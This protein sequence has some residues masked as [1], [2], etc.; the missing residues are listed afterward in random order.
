MKDR[1]NNNHGGV[2]LF[3]KDRINNNHG[4][5]GLFVKDRINN[6]HGGVGLFVKDRINNNHGGVGLFV[7]DRINNNHGGVGLFVKDRINNNHGGVG[8]F[9]KDR[10]NNN[11]GGVELF[12]KDRINNNHGGVG[13]FVKDRINN[14]HGGV[15][16]FVKDRINNNHG[17]VGLFVKDRI[18]N[19]HGGVGL[20]VKDRINNNHGGVGL[21]VKDRINNNHGGVGLFVKDR[22]NNNHGGVG[23]FVKDRI[24]NNH[25]GVGLFV[26][27]RIKNYIQSVLYHNDDCIYISFTNIPNVVFYGC[28]IPPNESLYY[29]NDIFA[30]L[31]SSLC[32]E[33]RLAVIF[34]D[35]NAKIKDFND[36]LQGNSLYSYNLEN[37]QQNRNGDILKSICINND[38]VVVNGLIEKYRKFDDSMTYKRRNKWISRIDMCLLSPTLISLIDSS[39]VIQNAHLPSDH[40]IITCTMKLDDN[41]AS[42]YILQRSSVWVNT[43]YH[44]NSR[45]RKRYHSML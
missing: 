31:S 44:L 12:V 13:L 23:L 22:I 7:K 19:N 17:G 6:N 27:D 10:I 5:V 39:S 43:M 41:V 20:F 26:K 11:H 38:M 3:V 29:N 25:G 1:I 30:T 8:L 21:F 15:G 14:N 42:E 40:A 34:G 32:H 18:N 24:N 16:L 4:G 9:V 45:E 33:N 35:F 28:Y 36:L 2:G 37:K